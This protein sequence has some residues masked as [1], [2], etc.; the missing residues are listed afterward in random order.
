MPPI[1]RLITVSLPFFS[2]PQF[3]GDNYAEVSSNAYRS[4]WQLLQQDMQP[5]PF[6][7]RP[8]Y[9]VP[10]PYSAVTGAQRDPYKDSGL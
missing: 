5:N 10:I 1:Q 4:L 3:I 8:D 9:L 7:P 6:E 2:A